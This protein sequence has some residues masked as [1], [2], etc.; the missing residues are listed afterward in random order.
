MSM[1]YRNVIEF[2][3]YKIS[4]IREKSV[5]SPIGFN[6]ITFYFSF[7][8]RIRNWSYIINTSNIRRETVS[9]SMFYLNLI[10]YENFKNS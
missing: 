1:N 3:R 4:K 8:R 10:E 7:L 2:S 6:L 5:V 9:I